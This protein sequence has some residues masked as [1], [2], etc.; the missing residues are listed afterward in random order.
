MHTKIDCSKI[1]TTRAAVL[2]KALSNEKRLIIL[3]HLLKGELCVHQLE[4]LVNLS[5]SALSQH[6][7]KL[8]SSNL[9]TTR[10]DAQTIY[11]R[12]KE[13]S[14]LDLIV[15]LNSIFIQENKST[16]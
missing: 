4:N 11:Y 5:Q 8:R 12:I 15:C 2:L 7:A 10:R 1:D 16:G 13:H 3:C 14:V 9:V 6:L